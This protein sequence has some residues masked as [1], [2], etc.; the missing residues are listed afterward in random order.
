MN[1]VEKPIIRAIVGY[2]APYCGLLTKTEVVTLE[3]AAEYARL[4][5]AVFVDPQDEA[6]LARWEQLHRTFFT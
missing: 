2:W 5:Y 6:E 3:E 1:T 4:G